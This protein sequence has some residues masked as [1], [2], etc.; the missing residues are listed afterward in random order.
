MFKKVDYFECRR[1]FCVNDRHLLGTSNG[2]VCISPSPNEILV[3]NPSTREVKKI[4]KPQ[5][6]VTDS[7]CSGFGYDSIND[8]YKIIIVRLFVLNVAWKDAPESMIQDST[9]FSTQ[10]TRASSSETSFVAAFTS[11]VISFLGLDLLLFLDF[12]L[13]LLPPLFL[14]LPLPSALSKVL[15]D[16]P[17]FLLLESSFKIRSRTLLKVKAS[18]PTGLV[19]AVIVPDQLSEFYMFYLF[20]LRSDNWKVIT[21]INYVFTSRVGMLCDGALHWLAYDTSPTKKNAILSFH[22]SDEKFLEVPTQDDATYNALY[23]GQP[24]L[25]RL[26]TM[27]GRLCLF[28]FTDV[29]HMWVVNQE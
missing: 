23:I 6:P 17:L 9:V 20:S 28:R 21:E 2:L 24:F 13:P 11:E 12:D 27:D 5:I 7:S 16:S 22:F 3:I 8:D 25:M 26:G 19:T 15:D 14:L 18:E 10:Q 4:T 1:C 29:H